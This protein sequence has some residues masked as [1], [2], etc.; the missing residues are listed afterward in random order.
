[1][2]AVIAATIS[3]S[4]A[5]VMA[6]DGKASIAWAAQIEPSN[7]AFTLQR[8]S[9]TDLI[10]EDKVIESEPSEN[11]KATPTSQS[12]Q[13]N[14]SYSA[15]S[16]GLNQARP[17]EHG[18][19]EILVRFKQDY[20]VTRLPQDPGLRRQAIRE[21]ERASRTSQARTIGLK[22]LQTVGF[23]PKET[24]WI[25]NA[26][27]GSIPIKTLQ[28]YTQVSATLGEAALRSLMDNMGIE[29]IEERKDL[30]ALDA[31]ITP[32]TITTILPG[33][34]PLAVREAINSDAYRPSESKSTVAI[35]DTGVQAD[36][37]LLT[38]ILNRVKDCSNTRTAT[39]NQNPGELCSSTTLGDLS[40]SRE[41]AGRPGRS[42]HGTSSA[43]VIAANSRM[44]S[45]LKGVT[46]AKVD[47]YLV[48]EPDP[49]GSGE[50]TSKRE[51]TLRAWQDIL[52]TSAQVVNLSM[53]SYN[54][55][56]NSSTAVAADHAFD[57]GLIVIASQG[58]GGGSGALE[59]VAAPAIA[60]KALAVGAINLASGSSL[61]RPG[62]YLEQSLGPAGDGRFKPDLQ[63]YTRSA[64]AA[65]GYARVRIECQTP[66]NC[67]IVPEQSAVRIQE[68]GATSGAAPF[69]SGA[70]NSIATW[71][72][73]W[74][75]RISLT[76]PG[77][78]Y[79][80]L[81]ANSSI[82][83]LSYQPD[84]DIRTKTGAGLL[85]LTDPAITIASR[86]RVQ[87]Q[88]S[89]TVNLEVP[90][91]A[92]KLKAAVW[93]PESA[94]QSHNNLDLFLIDPSGAIR[95]SSISRDSV[96]EVVEQLNPIPGRWRIQVR[97]T[98]VVSPAQEAF[99]V[100][101]HR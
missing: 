22:A 83:N 26:A 79:A 76:S 61:A 55:P 11:Q 94:N 32:E 14:Q 82:A 80:F 98:A 50:I 16:P 62:Q 20:P 9:G 10:I 81:L 21:I 49:D 45:D 18:K 96:W 24:F 13:T 51:S 64:A 93:W 52:A 38:N 72:K 56:E 7:Q 99:L 92:A 67:R 44:G 88:R 97:G 37:A 58:N 27:H 30:Q 17:D 6:K 36:H 41:R 54:T 23:V 70:A 69:V 84:L 15:L 34:W 60:H 28:H 89:Y 39:A 87:P 75:T 90:K 77:F 19:I 43:S 40:P 65:S 47:S 46:N 57:Y 29:Y 48:F 3:I 2:L 4:G 100:G 73:N 5:S 59:T 78:T 63:A 91:D 35:I 71:F 101:F 33:Q 53:G 86:L 12:K 68:Y 74:P 95:A 66:S 1:M 85:K 25:V 8:K 31:T 42:G